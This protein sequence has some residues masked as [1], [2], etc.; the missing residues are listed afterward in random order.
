MSYLTAM[1]RESEILQRVSQGD[2][3][4]FAALF[5]HYHQRLGLHIYK[6]TH[7]ADL[8]E[9]VVQDVFL[10]IWLHREL[11][12][13]VENFPVYLYVIYKNAALNCL[14]KTATEHA[15]V[16]DVDQY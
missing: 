15:R 10:K 2:E 6:I 8:A 16:E 7:S 12:D 14:K 4:A 3:R 9:E 1:H 11:L 5:N 13:G